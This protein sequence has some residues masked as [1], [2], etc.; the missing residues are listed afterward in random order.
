MLLR[1]LICL[2]LYAPLPCGAFSCARSRLKFNEVVYIKESSDECS[3]RFQ[4]AYRPHVP[5][6]DLAAA[7]F[8][9]KTRQNK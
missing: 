2:A 8:L 1:R 5:I 9:Q 7:K 3:F 4:L 6:P